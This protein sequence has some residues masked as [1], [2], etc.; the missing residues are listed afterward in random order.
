[1]IHLR[2]RSKIEFEEKKTLKTKPENRT[3]AIVLH[4]LLFVSFLMQLV[5]QLQQQQQRR[6]RQ[7]L[8][9]LVTGTDRR[10][11]SPWD[12]AAVLLLP[13]LLFD[14]LRSVAERRRL[15]LLLMLL[16]FAGSERLLLLLRVDD[17]LPVALPSL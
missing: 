13:A 14:L 4:C 17:P 2:G 15:L 8:S 16:L 5:S 11:R 9:Y 10:V 7:R 1:M 3:N 12:G 6:L